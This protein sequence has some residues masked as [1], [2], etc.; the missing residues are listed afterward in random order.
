MQ[1]PVR[2]GYFINRVWPT[3]PGQNVTLLTQITRPRFNPDFH[4]KESIEIGVNL[5]FLI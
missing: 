4:Y 5:A 2:P 1:N 3:L